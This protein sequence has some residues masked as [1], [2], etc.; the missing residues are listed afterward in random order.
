MAEKPLKFFVLAVISSLKRGSGGEFCRIKSPLSS[1]VSF[2]YELSKFKRGVGGELHE[3]HKGPGV[4]YMISL[5]THDSN[6][7]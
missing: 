5:T 7:Q 6:S 3:N 1:A 2:A 4:S